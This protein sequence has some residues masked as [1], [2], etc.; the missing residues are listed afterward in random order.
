[1][2]MEYILHAQIENTECKRHMLSVSLTQCF[3]RSVANY[4]AEIKTQVRRI[5]IIFDN[6][7]ILKRNQTIPAR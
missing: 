2:F 5:R 7:K 4:F 1:M 6:T 3:S